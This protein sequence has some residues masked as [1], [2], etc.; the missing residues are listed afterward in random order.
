MKLEKSHKRIIFLVSNDLVT[1]NRMHRICTSLAANNFSVELLGRQLEHSKSIGQTKFLPTRLK[2][3]FNKGFLFYAEL[4]I[5]FSA[6]F[7]D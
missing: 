4:N 5:L 2:L 3:I 1:D 7:K 6:L